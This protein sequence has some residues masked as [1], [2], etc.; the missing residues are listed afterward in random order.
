MGTP[1]IPS[2]LPTIEGSARH[3][4]PA[5]ALPTYLRRLSRRG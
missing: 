2:P 1:T 5:R 3:A 4:C